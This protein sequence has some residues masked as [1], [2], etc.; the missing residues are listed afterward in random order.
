[1]YLTKSSENAN[2][3]T[4]CQEC[5]NIIF[6]HTIELTKKVKGRSNFVKKKLLDM[7]VFIMK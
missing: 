5:T 6:H 4:P 3:L 7:Q 2:V 1:M